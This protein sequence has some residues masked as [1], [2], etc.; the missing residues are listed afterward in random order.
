MS[1]LSKRTLVIAGPTASGKSALAVEAALR[2]GGEVISADSRQVYRGMDIGTGKI[3]R[4]EQRGVPHFLLDVADPLEDYNAAHFLRDAAETETDIVGRGKLPIIAGGTGFWI[5]S[6]LEGRTFPE[7][8]PNPAL[9][10]E[11]RRLTSEELLER[12]KTVDPARAASIDAHNN[13][14]LI[15]SLEVAGALGRVPRL[16]KVDMEERNGRYRIMALDPDRR[17]LHEKIFRRLEERLEAGMIDEV[18]R[19]LQSGVTHERLQSFGLEYRFLSRFLLHELSET[20]MKSGLAAAI[21][22]YARRQLTWLR[23]MERQGWKIEWYTSSEEALAA[24]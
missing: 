3:T 19:L 12:L 8:A 21:R 22:Q 18:E 4:A 7:V 9:R 15:R 13:V 2:L 1:D 20:Q 10:E 23:R 11:L 14:R 5:Q 16:S 24:L 17:L 6:L